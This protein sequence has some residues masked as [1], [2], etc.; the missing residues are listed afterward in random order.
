MFSNLFEATAVDETNRLRAD[1][2][3]S[4]AD[5]GRLALQ[6]VDDDDDQWDY[7]M[8]LAGKRRPRRTRT[9]FNAVQLN[10]LESVFAR[11]HYP[12]VFTRYSEVRCDHQNQD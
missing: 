7:P 3:E 6:V 4:C 9:T 11:T 1:C 2:A 5:C 12:D 10:E 8:Q